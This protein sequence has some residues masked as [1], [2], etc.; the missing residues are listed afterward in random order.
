MRKLVILG[1]FLLS[2]SMYGESIYRDG[3]YRGFFPN[4]VAVEFQLKEDIV[5]S[6]RFRNL[7]YNGVDY[8]KETS[9][10][11]LKSQYEALLAHA[12]GKKI[13]TAMEDMYTP[14]KIERAGATLRAAKVRMALKNGV[15]HGP[16]S[17]PKE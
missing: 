10:A 13:D 6:A 2:F 17:L 3:T 14:E 7:T 5:Q 16:Y 1:A 9:V 4:E 12:I 11:R 15:I 8:L